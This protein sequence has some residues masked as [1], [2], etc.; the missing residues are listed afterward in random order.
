[1]RSY[2]I[3]VGELVWASNYCLNY[4]SLLY[5][6][7]FEQDDINIA[8][9]NW[10][11]MRSDRG[12]LDLLEVAAK[13]SKRITAPIRDEIVW[14]I[15]KAILLS[16]KRNDAVHT[17]TTFVIRP[18]RRVKLIPSSVST[19]PARFKRLSVVKNLI[20]SFG[21]ARNDFLQLS[22]YVF[23]LWNEVAFPGSTPLPK[24]PLL[25]SLPAEKQTMKK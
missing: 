24:R 20:R 9:G 8:I 7:L 5:R 6:E 22:G 1:V 3:A 12:Q 17:P 25:R 4:F 10:S 2:S 18:K 19:L 23:F 11:A 13:G 16:E 21:V 15:G 14:A